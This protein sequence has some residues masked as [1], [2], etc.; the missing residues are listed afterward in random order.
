MLSPCSQMPPARRLDWWKELAEARLESDQALLRP[1]AF[2]DRAALAEIAFDADTWRY[3]VQRIDADV[4]LDG[5]IRQAVED[6]AAK[7]RV[8][9]VVIDK[10]TGS[11]AGSMAYGNLA[12]ADRR[13]EIGWSWLGRA[14]KSTRPHAAIATS[15]PVGP[16]FLRSSPPIPLTTNSSDPM[17]SCTAVSIISSGRRSATC[18]IPRG[19]ATSSF[20]S[21]N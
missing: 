2:T 9:F 1:V 4:D 7:R 5:F 21:T 3:F 20:N 13:L 11:V 18:S 14:S 10:A 15:N 19:R 12:E 16:S 17:S 8:V 6:H